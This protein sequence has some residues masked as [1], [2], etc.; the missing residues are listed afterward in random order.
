MEDLISVI[1][2]TYLRFDQVQIAINSVLKQTYSNI[3]II[4]ID[5]CSPDS[6]YKLLD[7]MYETQ[8]NVKILHLPINQRDL[9]KSSY[10]QGQTRNEGIKIAK[11]KYLAFLDDDD[12]YCDPY[13]LETQ[14]LYVKQFGFC[15]TNMYIGNEHTTRKLY[16]DYNPN[17]L[18]LTRDDIKTTNYINTST[19]LIKKEIFEKSGG[20]Q[21]EINEDYECWKRIL[22]YTD[23]IYLPIPTVYYNDNNQKF[24]SY[25][26]TTVVTGYFTIPSKKSDAE[27]WSFI[28]N[29]LSLRCNMIIYTDKLNYDKFTGEGSKFKK[30]NI[31]IYIR[32][33]KDFHVYQYKDYWDYCKKIDKEDFHSEELYQVYNE[34]SFMVQDAIEKNP[35]NSEYFLWSDIGA[36]RTK[37]M[38]DDILTFPSNEKVEFVFLK[39]RFILSDVSFIPEFYVNELELNE[40]GISKSLENLKIDLSFLPLSIEIKKII[41]SYNT[42]ACFMNNRIQGGFMG[43]NKD[44]WKVWIE[45]YKEE[46][47]LFVKTK[48]FGGKDQNIM[49]NI[50]YKDVLD[51]KNDKDPFIM[52]YRFPKNYI[53]DNKSVDVDEWFA[54]LYCLS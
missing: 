10:A 18:K 43:G 44:M 49:N 46:L 54:Y 36:I 3:E 13:K 28:E 25:S 9:Y 39:D 51:I 21:I 30:H 38:V 14:L 12:A 20:F 2:P 24:Y 32:E 16:Y 7:K 33:L 52:A 23:C 19:V 41:N 11:G 48:T 42:I 6:N 29:F 1:I 40:H 27:Y 53:I 50:F 5:D 31:K 15:S 34:K 45:K 8:S 4:V 17:I 47:E 22:L 37:Q 26:K 35:F